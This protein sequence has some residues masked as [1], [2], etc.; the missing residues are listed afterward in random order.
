MV[1]IKERDRRRIFDRTL[2]RINNVTLDKLSHW[3][4]NFLIGDSRGQRVRF[5]H[6]PLTLASLHARPAL[7]NAMGT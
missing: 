7:S 3:L 5:H 2:N 4:V 6:Y 1:N